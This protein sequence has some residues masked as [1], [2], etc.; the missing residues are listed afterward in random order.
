M[1]VTILFAEA[2]ELVGGGKSP[3]FPILNN[4]ETRSR[5]DDS[6]SLNCSTSMGRQYKQASMNRLKL[7]NIPKLSL[8]VN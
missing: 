6:H 7:F 5:I 4:L 8:Y 1:F 3:S 2:T